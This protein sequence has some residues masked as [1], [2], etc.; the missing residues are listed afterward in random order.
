[1]SGRAGRDGAAARIHLLYSARDARINEHLLD[2][3]APTRDELVVLYRALQTMWRAA[4]TKTGEDSFAA[5]DLDIAQ[6]CLAIDAR[7]HVDER[8]VSCGLGVFEEARVCVRE[9][10]G[11]KSPYRHDREPGQG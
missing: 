1:M 3:L 9:G 7:T 2:A 10:F 5:S 8:S 11:C 6:M 4:R